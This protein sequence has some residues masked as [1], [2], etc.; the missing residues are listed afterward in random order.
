MRASLRYSEKVTPA[1]CLNIREIYFALYPSFSAHESRVK[2]LSVNSVSIIWIIFSVR[3]SLL[4]PSGFVIL[5]K[6]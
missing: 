2:P 4:C 3:F 1:P 5:E 6:E